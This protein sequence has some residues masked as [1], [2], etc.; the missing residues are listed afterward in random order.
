MRK[1][2]TYLFLAFLVTGRMLAQG[3]DPGTESLTH[4]WTFEDGTVD[5]K[6]GIAH[7]ELV[8]DNIAVEDGDLVAYPNANGIG[9]SWVELPGADLDLASYDEVAVSAWFTPSP[10]FNIEW[11]SVWF[12]GDNGAGAGTGSDGMCLQARRGDG[13]ARFWFTAGAPA[14]Y[15]AEDGV[16]DDVYGNY[17]NDELYHVVCQVNNSNEIMMYHDGELVGITP[18]TTNPATG[19]IKS[20]VDISPNFALFCTSGYATD[21]PWVGS[22]HEIAIFNKALSDEEVIF[23]FDA[24]VNGFPA[25]NNAVKNKTAQLPGAFDLSQNYPNPFNPTTNITFTLKQQEPVKLAV[26]DALGKQVVSLLDETRNAGEHTITFDAKGLTSGVYYY[27]LSTATGSI[28]NK[29]LLMK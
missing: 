10:D 22:I 23:L 14:G 15:N 24:G 9:D 27:K 28:T 2:L 7:G 6:I 29:M 11:N 25:A 1:K 16:N 26:Y 5:D 17:N 4:L 19:D 21:N 18:L 12:F 13:H 3:V 20:I 8:G